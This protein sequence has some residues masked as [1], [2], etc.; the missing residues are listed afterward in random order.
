MT[1]FSPFNLS[2]LALPNRVVMA[3]MTR[4]RAEHG[5]VPSAHVAD[6]YGQRAGAGLIITESIEVDP[7]SGVVPPTRPG[8]AN[9]AQ[10]A[11]WSHVTEAVH[12]K[13][14][15]IFAQLSHMGRTA[16][17]ALLLPGGRVIGPSPLAAAGKIYTSAGALPYETPEE[18]SLADITEV[19]GH[20]AKA[21]ERARRA[22]FDGVELHGANGY[23]ID[24]FLRDASNQRTDHYGGSAEKRA[25]LLVEIFAAVAEHWPAGRVGIRVSPTNLF[26][27]MGDS[28]PVSHFG[29]IAGLLSGFKPAYLHVV[30]PYAQAP[31]L[32]K[33][34]PAIRAAFEGPIIVAG[35]YEGD[36]AEAIIAEGQADLVAFGEKFISNPDLPRRL[37]QGLPLA[38]ADKG[39]FYTTEAKGY[40]DYPFHPD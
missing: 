21:A 22:G 7:L 3:P 31:G 16:H 38:P 30:E 9:D 6:Y 10:E 24:Q 35:K 8:F 29:T 1:L 27:G 18:M 11:G 20:Y 2:G 5:K 23:L 39:T 37:Q 13:G 32:P 4:H 15:R 34:L 12:A 40:S 17:P 25:R 26:Q 14:G 33:V 19:I 36:S 28:D